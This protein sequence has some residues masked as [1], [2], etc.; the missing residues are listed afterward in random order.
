MVFT[1]CQPVKRYR[2]FGEAY[3]LYIQAIKKYASPKRHQ[4]LL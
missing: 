1:S 3:C 2:R 4:I